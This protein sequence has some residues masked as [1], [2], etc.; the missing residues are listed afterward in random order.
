[1]AIP[2]FAQR[3]KAAA[4]KRFVRGAD[5]IETYE[6]TV[7]N[8]T[9]VQKP[10][11]GAGQTDASV[12]MSTWKE[13]DEKPKVIRP[14]DVL[15][16]NPQPLAPEAIVKLGERVTIAP[17]TVTGFEAAFTRNHSAYDVTLDG[18]IVKGDQALEAIYNSL[19]E[20]QSAPKGKAK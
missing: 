16:A 19:R 9:E 2:N 8:G 7:E 10:R 13:A 4:E 17:S 20:I 11:V 1:M 3:I 6:V 18:K 5:G 12:P 14:A 15:D